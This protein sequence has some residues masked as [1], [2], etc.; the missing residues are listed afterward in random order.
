[1]K[2]VSSISSWGDGTSAISYLRWFP[3]SWP[4]HLRLHR[5]QRERHLRDF[6]SKGFESRIE[7][8]REAREGL[9]DV[10]QNLQRYTGS[11]GERRLLEPLA[12]LRSECIS[13]RQPDAVTEQ[14]Q[15]S[16]R[17]GVLM[18]VRRGLGHVGQ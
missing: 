6:H 5:P 3:R 9:D 10:A 12:G 14:G 16:V 7:D 11:Y 15:E 4:R 2:W 13:T 8:G 1:M 18:A 17:L